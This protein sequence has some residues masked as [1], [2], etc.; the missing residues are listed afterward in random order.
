MPLERHSAVTCARSDGLQV[1]MRVRP[2]P[3]HAASSSSTTG[4][5]LAPMRSSSQMPV[6]RWTEGATPEARVGLT[7][8]ENS[9]TTEPSAASLTAPTSM[10]SKKRPLAWRRALGTCV[11][12]RSM[13]TLQA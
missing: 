8:R 13:T 1:T 4:S 3:I 6:M 5:V 11:N 12:S 9:P 2:V 10:I 7:M